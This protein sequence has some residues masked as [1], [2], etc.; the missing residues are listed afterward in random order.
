MASKNLELAD[1]MSAGLAPILVP[2]SMSF[3]FYY[4]L[5]SQNTNAGCILDR[6]SKNRF[7]I[8]DVDDQ[9]GGLETSSVEISE[10]S[11]VERNKKYNFNIQRLEYWGLFEELGYGVGIDDAFN[12]YVID[13][14]QFATNIEDVAFSGVI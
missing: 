3:V 6:L 2:D 9:T 11:V 5:E 8:W 14:D 10:Q 12:I 7:L 13:Y 1:Y 4:F